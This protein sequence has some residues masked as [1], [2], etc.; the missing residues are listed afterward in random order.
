MDDTK[1]VSVTAICF[2]RRKN[3]VWENGIA[4]LDDPSGNDV[5]L[6]VDMNSIP[7]SSEDVWDFY[8]QWWKGTVTIVDD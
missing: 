6:I 2:R 4:I 8:L 1:S 7:I 3:S 5:N